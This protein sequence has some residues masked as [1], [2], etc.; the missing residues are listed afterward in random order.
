MTYGLPPPRG[1]IITKLLMLF[2]LVMIIRADPLKIEREI[3]HPFYA[4]N[5][6]PL[7]YEIAYVNKSINLPFPEVNY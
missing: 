3:N 6:M 7:T 2:C 1:R 4:K 5:K